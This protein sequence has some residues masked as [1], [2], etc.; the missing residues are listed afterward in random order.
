MKILVIP[1]VHLKPG[2][3]DIADAVNKETYDNVVCLGDIVDDW[4]QENNQTL[5]EDTL[6]RLL[7][8]DKN[9]PEMLWCWGNHDT[10]YMYYKRETGFSVH[11]APLVGKYLAKMEEQI[12][13]RLAVIHKIDNTLFSHAGL[14]EE[15]VTRIFGENT[16]PTIDEIIE[17]TN[18]FMADRDVFN[19][20]WHDDSPLWVRP[21]DGF[22]NLRY[23][24]PMYKPAEFWQI[25]G[26]TP[27]KQPFS[28]EMFST[29]DTKNNKHG[30]TTL[31]NYLA[32]DT[33]STRSNHDPIGNRRFVI[34]DT[35]KNKWKYA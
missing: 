12:G 31:Q 19:E 33:F 9:H 18:S 15:Y 23:C 2:M 3:F 11:M 32:L 21:F 28:S 25:I 16:A 20:L 30:M 14:C 22:G 26:H 29:N 34:V 5:Y 6:E 8:F 17:K 7:E 1:D 13:D 10:S 4:G 27:M 35:V 24:I